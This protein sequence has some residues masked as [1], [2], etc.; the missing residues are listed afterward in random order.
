MEIKRIIVQIF[1]CTLT[2]IYISPLVFDHLLLPCLQFIVFSSFSHEQ[3]CDAVRAA[4]SWLWSI[5]V[6]T[7]VQREA[8]QLVHRERVYRPGLH[9]ICGHLLQIQIKQNIFSSSKVS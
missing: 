1:Y 2:I 5:T 8:L 7:G 3:S 9:T 6:V 4:G